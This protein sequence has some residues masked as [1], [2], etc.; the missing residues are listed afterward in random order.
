MRI[1]DI[2]YEVAGRRM[3]GHLAVDEYRL[4]PRP[5]VLVCHEG[6]GLDEHV[7]GRAVRLASLGY[8][9]F[10]LDYQG[11][12]VP[13]PRE[14]AMAALDLLMGDRA[15]TVLIGRAGWEVMLSQPQADRSRVAALGYCFGGT[16]AIELARDGVDLKAVIGFHPG[17]P[18]PDVEASRRIGAKVLL[19]CGAD[20]PFVP[21]EAR[22]AFEAELT[23]AGVADWRMEVYGGVG[24]SY[25]NPRAD[26]LGIAGLAFDA[27][28]DRR[29]WRSALDLLTE[30]LGPL[31]P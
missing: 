13:K 27:A 4:G 6:P 10:A 7:K 20:D 11:D 18:S 9:A 26:A 22:H 31:E 30:S 3:V 29:S 2:D 25:T 21:A 24:H 28:A 19:C 16:M 23:E 17:M 15:Q 14:E 8:L 1:E 12:G 5:C